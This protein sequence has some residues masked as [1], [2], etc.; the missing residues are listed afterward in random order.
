VPNNAP[1]GHCPKCLLELGFGPLPQAPEA[2]SQPAPVG[3]RQFGDY[4]LVEQI[5]RGGMGIIYKARQATLNRLVAIKMIRAPEFAS[6][7]LIQRFHLEAEAAANLHHP[8]IVPIFETG[9]HQGEH[10]FSMALVDGFGLD[11]YITNAGFCFERKAGEDKPSVRARQEQIARLMAKVAR[12]VDYA[13]QHGVLHRDLKPANILLDRQGEPHLTDFGVAKVLGHSGISLTASGSIMGTPSYMAPEQAA[14]QSKRVTTAADIY[15]LGAILYEMLTG[16]PP[17]R[18]DTPVETLKQ[19]IEQDPKHPTTFKEGVDHDLATVCMKCLEKEP[20]RRYNSAAALAEDLERWLRHEPIQA[21]PVNTAERLW[22]WGRRNPKVATLG[23][24][25]AVLLILLTLG[26]IIAAIVFAGQR[27]V[28]REEV[29]QGLVDVF[30][31]R[32]PSYEVSSPMRRALTSSILSA[33]SRAATGRWAKTTSDPSL[34]L[35]IILHPYRYP[36]NMLATFSPILDALE[37][38]LSVKLGTNVAINLRMFSN[39]PPLHQAMESNELSF[40]RMGPS[41]YIEL[42]ERGSGISLLAMQ[43]H[44]TPLTLAIFVRKDSPIA[45]R[46]RTNSDIPLLLLLNNQS[47]ALGDTKSTTGYHV[48]CWYLVKKGI[49]A[50][51]FASVAHFAG[52][53]RV[54][55][56]VIKGEASVG[57]GNLDLVDDHPE[58]LVIAK[59]TLEGDLGLC[60]VAGNKLDP[61]ITRE[62]Q[63][64]LLNL[65]GKAILGRLESEVTGFK[66]LNK[67]DVAWLLEEM[68]REPKPF[69]KGP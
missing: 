48:A 26:S 17:F 61:T 7:T 15:S 49:Y 32:R 31:Q 66:G 38:Q 69:F 54:I 65:K 63:S 3:G 13:H 56:A 68:R 40:A 22:R 16:Q 29:N 28:I 58:L 1:F 57:V 41:S 33:L 27:S 34:Q 46:Y 5:G 50:S 62:L 47:M 9:E 8:N 11:R 44:K 52:Q 42:L 30:A 43:D 37:D 53:Q 12:A 39:Y 2:P 36:T 35:T 20:Q 14:G 6:P 55:D 67:Q 64:C 21:R 25:V 18:A 19:V 4:E 45:T 59:H 51:Y 10:F 24:S 23:A 60:W